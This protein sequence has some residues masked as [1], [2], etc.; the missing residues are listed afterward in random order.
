MNI[1]REESAEVVEYGKDGLQLTFTILLRR[2]QV[3]FHVSPS[4][5]VNVHR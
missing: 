4:R 2:L 1:G 5:H 3:P